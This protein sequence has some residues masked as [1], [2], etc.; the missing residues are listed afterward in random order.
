MKPARK[1]DT[2]SENARLVYTSDAVPGIRRKTTAQGF[3]YLRPDGTKVAERGELERIAKLAVPPAYADVWI[4]TDPRG[5]L[6][7][8]GRD[9]RGRKQYRYHAQWRF[10]RDREN[11]GVVRAV[12]SPRTTARDI[13]RGTPRER[14]YDA[15]SVLDATQV[16]IGNECARARTAATV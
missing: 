13:R 11:S 1:R 14:S 16:R 9:A 15:I 3:I 2:E 7:A 10:V 8:T 4:C 12:L 5:H 6:Q